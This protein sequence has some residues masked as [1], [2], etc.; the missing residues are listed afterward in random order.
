[1]EKLFKVLSLIGK[2]CL[3]TY[4]FA[5]INSSGSKTPTVNF[6]SHKL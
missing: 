2:T 5:K 1:M 4:I 6:F 3:N